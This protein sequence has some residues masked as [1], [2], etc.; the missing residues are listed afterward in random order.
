MPLVRSHAKQPFGTAVNFG[1]TEACLLSRR[2]T[3]HVCLLSRIIQR[4]FV[5]WK[6]YHVI[7]RC[8]MNYKRKWSVVSQESNRKDCQYHFLIRSKVQLLTGGSVACRAGP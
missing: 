6:L 8:A 3:I 7:Q 2:P 5:C 1:R 4:Y